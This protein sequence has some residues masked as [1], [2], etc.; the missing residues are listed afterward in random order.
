MGWIEQELGEKEEVG[1]ALLDWMFRFDQP[2]S[3]SGGLSGL[4]NWPGGNRVAAR[5][6]I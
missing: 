4:G 6:K 1:L 3:C 5:A 2:I